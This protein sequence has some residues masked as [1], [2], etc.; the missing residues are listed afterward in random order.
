M[1]KRLPTEAYMILFLPDLFG[2]Q[3]DRILYLDIDTYVVSQDLS[4]MLDMDIGHH[5]VAGVRE[6]QQWDNLNRSVLEFH[7]RGLG[8]LKYLNTGMVLFDCPRFLKADLLGQM[9]EANR[10]YVDKMQHD[11]SLFNL[12]LK[13]E[14]AEINP[15]WNW[16][17]TRAFPLFTYMISPQIIHFQS[18]RKPWNDNEYQR[19]Y[20]RHLVMEYYQFFQRHFPEH[21][22]KVQPSTVAR[23]SLWE[24]LRESLH[25]IYKFPSLWRLMRRFDD[26]WDVLL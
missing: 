7:K 16:Q 8:R 9:L 15:V 17:W 2:D 1:T 26:D 11:Q 20:S 10:T 18:R 12:V 19:L 5:A 13:G 24:I 23:A 6:I 14:W 22:F 21:V 25:H 4:R 3:Y